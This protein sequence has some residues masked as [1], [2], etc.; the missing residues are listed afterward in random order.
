MNE[1]A[2]NA[3]VAAR[4]A[5]RVFI[6]LAGFHFP[7]CG[8][9]EFS[10]SRNPAVA[11]SPWPSVYERTMQRVAAALKSS[12]GSFARYLRTSQAGCL[13]H[14]RRPPLP[15][16]NGTPS[17]HTGRRRVKRG[18]K[19]TGPGAGHLLEA[20]GAHAFQKSEAASPAGDIRGSH[21]YTSHHELSTLGPLWCAGFSPLSRHDEFRLGRR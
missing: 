15:Q 20:R 10:L 4:G 2:S 11:A 1:A 19:S 5:H 7:V 13:G 21:G 8:P 9:T 12:T 14:I 17:S 16:G 18:N 6:R 3:A